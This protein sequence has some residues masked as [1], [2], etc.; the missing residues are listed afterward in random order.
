V[1]EAAAARGGV[2]IVDATRRG[3]SFPDGEVPLLPSFSLF[4]SSLFAC[5]SRK[6]SIMR[7]INRQT[8]FFLKP[9]HNTA[10]MTKTIPFWCAV[11]NR[12]VARA[13]AADPS[14]LPTPPPPPSHPPPA[15]SAHPPPALHHTAP[16]TPAEEGGDRDAEPGPGEAGGCGQGEGEEEAGGEAA[17]VETEAATW[18]TDLHVV[19]MTPSARD[20]SFF[21]CYFYKPRCPFH[22]PP[23]K[24][25][26][27]G[28][29][30]MSALLSLNP[31]SFLTVLL[32]PYT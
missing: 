4:F 27:C 30:L 17:E 7:Y 9:C 1:A 8:P 13:R 23:M 10:A 32:C 28:C 16:S 26:P 31:F 11:V 18:D 21:L 3:K 6:D 15:L 19:R 5:S 2:I 25:S 12:A 14:L 20:L 24:Y 22:N 29:P